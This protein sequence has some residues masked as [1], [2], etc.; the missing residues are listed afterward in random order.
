MEHTI[1]ILIDGETV[2]SYPNLRQ[3]TDNN[4]ILSY[5]SLYRQLKKTSVITVDN[6]TIAV[7]KMKWKT[8]RG[9]NAKA[10]EY[11]Q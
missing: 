2:K 6:M 9:F 4:A 3:L 5:F 7:T 8:K 10:N 11:E 1:Y